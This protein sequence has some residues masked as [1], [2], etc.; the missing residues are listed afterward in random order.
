MTAFLLT[1]A[2]RAFGTGPLPTHRF[3]AR[4]TDDDPDPALSFATSLGTQEALL[5]V[6][7]GLLR[8]DPRRAMELLY[9][10]DD[11]AAAKACLV[12]WSSSDAN[13]GAWPVFE[14]AAPRVSR[15]TRDDAILI[16]RH[17]LEQAE[18]EV[19]DLRGPRPRR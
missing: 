11:P 3:I 16:G 17:R 2:A 8:D 10:L 1:T 7:K 12:S 4:W 19:P 5:A 14:N 9:S 18:E 15:V 6:A 13:D